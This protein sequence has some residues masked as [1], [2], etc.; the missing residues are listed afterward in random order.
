MLR[1]T[2]PKVPDNSPITV[3]DWLP[4]VFIVVIILICA[5]GG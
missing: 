1:P 5:F 2:P 4:L 3:R